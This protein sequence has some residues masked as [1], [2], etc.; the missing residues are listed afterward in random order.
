MKRP[1]NNTLV[2]S[3]WV[4]LLYH[5]IDIHFFSNTMQ[6]NGVSWPN[7]RLHGACEDR[8]IRF[9]MYRC[10]WISFN[11][12]CMVSQGHLD[13]RGWKCL[14]KVI[15][16]QRARD[17]KIEIAMLMH[18]LNVQIKLEKIN[19]LIFKA[20][21]REAWLHQC[22]VVTH[23]KRPILLFLSSLISR[24]LSKYHRS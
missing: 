7:L 11:L 18:K 12:K 24:Q 8:I 16:V 14:F 21:E 13:I 15:L 5:C 22:Y 4:C 3:Q 2:K 17:L 23:F 1:W 6:N 9:F 20:T 10:I 19:M